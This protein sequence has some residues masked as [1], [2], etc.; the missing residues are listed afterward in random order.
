MKL[1]RETLS[2]WVCPTCVFQNNMNTFMGKQQE[3]ISKIPQLVTDEVK[4]QLEQL[5]KKLNLSVDPINSEVSSLKQ[6]TDEIKKRTMH[7]QGMECRRD[8]VIS[9]IPNHVKDAK[10]IRDLVIKIGSVFGIGIKQE[11]I[12]QCFRL[13]PQGNVIVKFG[14]LF[15]KDD[16]MSS[17]FKKMDLK[18]C[19]FMDT[20][21]ESRV[22][23]NN[24]LPPEL[25]RTISYCRRLKK[26]NLIA[27]FKVNFKTGEAEI[28]ALDNSSRKY[29]D[30]KDILSHYKLPSNEA[31]NN[32]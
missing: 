11:E 2:K 13:K 20:N 27:G 9:G 12:V 17:Y 4:I 7:L 18:L 22:Y 26:L 3:A 6:K 15:T 19:D 8:V 25:Q 1:T 32:G 24:N 21:V 16:L 5:E 10:V 30:F 14:N 23:L 31:S 28:Q 29:Q